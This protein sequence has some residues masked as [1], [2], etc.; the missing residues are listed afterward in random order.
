MDEG[1]IRLKLKALQEKVAVLE[2]D[3]DS[4]IE[5]LTA[6]INALTI[7]NEELQGRCKNYEE[8]EDKYLKCVRQM[9]DEIETITEENRKLIKE[10]SEV[11]LDRDKLVTNIH[12]YKDKCE[13]IE[14][15][16][17]A[18]RS[19]SRMLSDNIKIANERIKHLELDSK[20]CSDEINIIR[21]GELKQLLI[22]KEVQIETLRDVIGRECE[23]RTDLLI[24]L[25]ELRE[26]LSLSQP[27]P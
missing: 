19:E 20:K 3:R 16:L 26:R 4:E 17:Q 18:K 13:E 15:Q 8:G 2:D 7:T 9:K 6:T 11:S 25:S 23:E 27:H 10:I 1:K 24:E 5:R 21:I 22:A 12:E 14:K